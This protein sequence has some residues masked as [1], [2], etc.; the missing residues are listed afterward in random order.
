MKY[1]KLILF[2]LVTNYSYAQYGNYTSNNIAISLLEPGIALEYSI[3][4]K[5]S[6]GALYHIVT[7]S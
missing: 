7:T 2:L 5:R 4:P 3:A 1:L 6:S